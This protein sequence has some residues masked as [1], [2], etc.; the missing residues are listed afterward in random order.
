MVWVT[1]SVNGNVFE[2]VDEHVAAYLEAE[3]HEIHKSDPRIRKA[4]KSKA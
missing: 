4:S 2:V 1:S 3:G